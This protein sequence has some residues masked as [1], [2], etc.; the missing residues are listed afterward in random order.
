M[1]E[2]ASMPRSTRLRRRG[3]LTIP[4]EIRDALSLDERTSLTILGVGKALI[5]TPKPL[6]RQSLAKT[7][8]KEM[9]LEGVTLKEL[10]SD[11]RVQLKRYYGETGRKD[12]AL[13]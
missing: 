8:E 3:Q 9:K 10:I 12:Y 4:Q 2:F 7:A 13:R 5:L 1:S 6:Q 11:L